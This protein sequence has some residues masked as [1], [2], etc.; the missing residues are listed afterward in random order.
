MIFPYPDSSFSNTFVV[1][2]S[3]TDDSTAAQTSIPVDL[4]IVLDRVV[5]RV[6]TLTK[7]D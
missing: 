3:K 7:S 2:A 6:G 5:L 4:M 1:I